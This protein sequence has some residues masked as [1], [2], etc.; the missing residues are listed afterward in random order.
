LSL[1]AEAPL[2]AGRR[3]SRLSLLAGPRPSCARRCAT[4]HATRSSTLATAAGL[5]R[6]DVTS[7]ASDSRALQRQRRTAT[8]S[9]RRTRARVRALPSH[10]TPHALGQPVAPALG[11]AIVRANRRSAPGHVVARET[12]RRP[13][14]PR[15]ISSSRG[16]RQRQ[17]RHEARERRDRAGSERCERWK[18]ETTTR[19]AAATTGDGLLEHCEDELIAGPRLAKS[20][21]RDDGPRPRWKRPP[22][23]R[24]T[25]PVMR[26]PH[27]PVELLWN[28]VFVVRHYAG[29]R[30]CL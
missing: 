19:N 22:S 25:A 12:G 16:S 14:G 3:A 15:S 27:E 20:R 6:L 21:R 17:P 30:R 13:M 29:Q 10:W 18:T 24:R 23:G 26:P 4:S 8:G 9:R 28:L 1:T 5:V 2:R 7:L 11:L